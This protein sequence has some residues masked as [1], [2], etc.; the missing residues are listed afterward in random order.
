ME[1]LVIPPIDWRVITPLLIV[2]GW[3][4]LLLLID[5]FVIGERGKRV[6]AYLAMA[7]LVAAGVSGIPL[8][9]LNANTFSGMIVLDNFALTLIWIFVIIGVFIIG[10]AIDY[11]PRQGIEEG[12][13]YPLVL[14]AV[15]G[16]M[17]LAQGSDLIVLFLGLELLSIT[18]YI[19][20]GFAY[21]RVTS[22]EAA[23]KYLVLGAFAAGFFVYG[24]ALIYGATGASSF[25][26]IAATLAEGS[27]DRSLLMIGAGLVLVAFGF[28]T[29][30]APFQFWTPDVYEGA[31]TPV[32]AFMSVGTKGAAFAALIRIVTLALPELSFFWQPLLAALAALT[33]LVGNLGALVQQNIKRMLAYSSIGHAGYILLA[34]LALGERG[35][36]AFLYYFMAY[37]LTNLGAFAVVIALEQRGEALWSLNDFDGLFRR[38]PGLA[39][40][41]AVFM[42]SLA[43]VPPLAGFFAKLYVFTAAY[44]VGWGFLVLIGVITSAIAA[45]FYLRVV[46]RMFMAEPGRET[47]PDVYQK[48]R[49]S[50]AIA[51]L[52]VLLLGLIPA[53]VNTLIEQSLIALGG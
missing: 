41:M 34:V 50:I 12:E 20:T 15:G 29:S 47:Q 35:N 22:E 46:V 5:V 37:T 42:L 53:P 33:M 24:I 11:L 7:G 16:M 1:T 31:P 52:A 43:G 51:A 3:G 25:S 36:E 39:L 2:L 17:L 30:L 26:A 32:A 27:A 6:T 49:I 14:F 45:A 40:A 4:A 9:N 13:F 18:L 19:L 10:L 48:L 28:K 8:W 21:P 44:D 38:Y 23:M